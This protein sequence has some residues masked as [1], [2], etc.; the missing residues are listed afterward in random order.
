MWRN[1]KALLSQ[2]CRKKRFY[3]GY[4]AKF[5][6]L[7]RYKILK[8]DPLIEFFIYTGK[9]YNSLGAIEQEYI[10]DDQASNESDSNS[11]LC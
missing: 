11:E 6:F 8:L 9:L 2:Y 4:L 7:K 3:G 1:A 5:I 10:L